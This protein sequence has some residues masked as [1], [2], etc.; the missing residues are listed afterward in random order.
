MSSEGALK[1]ISP[2]I[3]TNYWTGF[4]LQK[5]NKLIL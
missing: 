1:Y 3:N 4:Y 2:K 5:M